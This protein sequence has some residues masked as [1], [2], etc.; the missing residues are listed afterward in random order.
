MS[1]NYWTMTEQEALMNLIG[2]DEWELP[3]GNDED[4]WDEEA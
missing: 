2:M 1:T 4:P 3:E